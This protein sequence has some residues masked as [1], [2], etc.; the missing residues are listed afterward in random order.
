MPLWKNVTNLLGVTAREELTL[1]ARL[2]PTLMWQQGQCLCGEHVLSSRLA[3]QRWAVTGLRE[4]SKSVADLAW[5]QSLSPGV[6]CT[7]KHHFPF[8]A[9]ALHTS[10]GMKPFENLT[11]V[12]S[13]LPG[14][15]TSSCR[16]K[17]I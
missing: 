12:L 17:N 2:Q 13:L 15:H 9:M 6:S 3:H 14:K 4:H 7:C 1:A 10:G 5:R 16:C 8:R 11:H